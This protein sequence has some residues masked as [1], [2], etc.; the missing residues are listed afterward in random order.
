M[1][2]SLNPFKAD[3]LY[4]KETL[5]EEVLREINKLLLNGETISLNKIRHNIGHGSYSTIARIL[6]NE[7]IKTTRGSHKSNV[8][9]ITNEV[10]MRISNALLED[11]NLERLKIKELK[12]SLNAA[13][14]LP[15]L[16]EVLLK[17][18]ISKIIAKHLDDYNPLKTFIDNAYFSQKISQNSKDVPQKSISILKEEKELLEDY[19]QDIIKRLIAFS[20]EVSPYEF[21]GEESSLIAMRR[22]LKDLLKKPVAANKRNTHEQAYQYRY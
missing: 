12:A 9:K 10:E 7:G 4:M 17:E 19:K 8:P 15:L 21:V 16:K 20:E 14:S 13:P 11:I 1:F 6:K 22:M 5:Q 2:L 18:V 3:S